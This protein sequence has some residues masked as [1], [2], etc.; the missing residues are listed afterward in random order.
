MSFSISRR[1]LLATAAASAVMVSMGKLSGEEALPSVTVSKDPNCG[2]CGAWV[3]HLRQAG[4]SV[5]V[6][7]TKELPAIKERLGVPSG[8]ASCHTAEVSGYVVEGHVPADAIKRLLNEKP[9]ATGLAVPGMPI[10]SPGMEG[11]TP[12]IYEVVLFGR[13]SQSV[14]ARY[15]GTG[16]L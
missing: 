1:A 9:A 6:R 4:F 2:C 8:L 13:Q 5:S 14:F 16:A 11:G 12:E 7:D 10:G 15:R 3:A